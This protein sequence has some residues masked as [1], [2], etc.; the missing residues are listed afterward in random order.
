MIIDESDG[1]LDAGRRALALGYDGMSH[2]NCKGIVKGIL[3]RCR[4]EMAAART[5]GRTPLMS[6]E[7]LANIGPVALAQDLGVQALLGNRSVE[8]NGHH[9]FHGLSMFPEPTQRTLVESHPDLFEWH[10]EGFAR[11]RVVD[12]CL[13]TRSVLEAPFGYN[14]DLDP[15]TIARPLA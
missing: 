14:F 3:N 4:V 8:R 2:K 12:G 15:A 13:S 9:Y 1:D 6:G 11:L 10:P 5:D 7:D